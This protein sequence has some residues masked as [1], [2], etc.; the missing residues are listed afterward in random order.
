MG[1]RLAA[2][3]FG[4]A[5]GFVLSWAQATDPD[6]I[7]AMLKLDDLYLFGMLAS[8]VAVASVGVRLLRRAGAR[9][10]LTRERVD[11]ATT[12]P[13]RRHVVGSVLFGT[14]WAVADACPGPVAA[15]IGQGF[16]WSLFTLV[17]VVLGVAMFLRRQERAEGAPERVA[18]RAAPTR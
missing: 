12:A 15:Q 8:A 7:H 5:F 18:A 3:L 2:G 9:A 10:L 14:G 16:A 1:V 6:R 13:A 11:W 17:G 4:A